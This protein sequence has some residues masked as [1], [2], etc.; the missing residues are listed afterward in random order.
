LKNVWAVIPARAGSKG[1]PNKN[2][3]DLDGIPLLGH[4]IKFAQKLNYVDKIF[5]S[6]D[7]DEYASIGRKLGAFVPFLRSAEASADHSMEEDILFDISVGCALHSLDLPDIVIW[8]RPTHPLREIQVF[9]RAYQKYLTGIYNSVCVVTPE[10]PRVFF[11]RNGLLYSHLDDFSFKSMVRRQDCQTAYRIFSGEI[12]AFPEK[13]NKKFLG[14]KIGFEV[15]DKRCKFDID[16]QEDLD[17]LNYLLK[18]KNGKN[19]YKDFIHK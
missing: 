2:I 15:A 10:D 5:L 18:T 7:S 3:A 13:F 17:Y 16:Y 1:Y 9:D 8:L 12:F 14:E 19:R 11:D 4:S 6:T